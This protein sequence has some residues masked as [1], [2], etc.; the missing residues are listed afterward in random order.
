MEISE[1]APG[2]G[3]AKHQ[4]PEELAMAMIQ[5]M[6]R[7]ERRRI[8]RLGH[9]ERKPAI[10]LRYFIVAAL[11][12][13]DS[14]PSVERMF[15]VARSTV[16]DVAKRFRT[17]G[18]AALRDRREGNGARKVDAC[19]ERALV[20]LLQRSPEDFGWFRPTWTREL[21]AKQLVAEGH[22]EVSVTTLGRALA[23]VGA[24]LGTPKPIVLCPWPRAQRVQRLAEIRALEQHATISEPVLYVDE[25]DIHL[26]PKVGRDW[27]L[28]GQQRR[29]VTPGKNEK[30]YIAGG[31]DVLTGKLIT[32]GLPK[33]NS[34][35]FIAFLSVL[36]RHYSRARRIHLVLDNYTIHS[37]KRSNAA[38]ETY[39]DR[40]V[41]HFLPPYCPD[42]NRI[43]RVWQDL[44]ANVTRNHRCKTLFALLGRAR[45]F[46]SAYQWKRVSAGTDHRVMRA[47]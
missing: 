5:R 1:L 9:K 27:M 21:L 24:R 38:L 15:E 32:T 14:S 7:S 35:L 39:G 47:A 20:R 2:S 13:G 6:C 41:L 16:V 44:H 23:S 37:S 30:F 43:E 42:A 4:T 18:L 12:R 22:R 26:N 3:I 29:L 17:G 25:V 36:D 40:F 11:G 10:A 34:E 45:R 28:P 31:L 33:K 8:A 46:V 19:F